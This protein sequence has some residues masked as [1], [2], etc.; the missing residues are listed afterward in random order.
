MQPKGALTLSKK[1]L[2]GGLM[3][4]GLVPIAF[5]IVEK[6]LSV[7]WL[8]NN[9]FFLNG[10]L[11]LFFP[12][13]V[14]VFGLVTAYLFGQAFQYL[15]I[16]KD[17]VDAKRKG[18]GVQPTNEHQPVPFFRPKTEKRRH[19]AHNVFPVEHAPVKCSH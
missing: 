14:L 12:Y 16:R 11:T 8:P 7:N 15:G 1:S 17:E 6:L 9:F 2:L 3:S 10:K 13:F 5:N 19:V 4:S 18:L